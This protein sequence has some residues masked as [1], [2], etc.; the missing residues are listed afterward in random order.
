M[1]N[2]TDV[3]KEMAAPSLVAT[4]CLQTGKVWVGLGLYQMLLYYKTGFGFSCFSHTNI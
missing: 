1:V 3:L 2:S 4:G